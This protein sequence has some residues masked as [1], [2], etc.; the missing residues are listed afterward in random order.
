MFTRQIPLAV[1]LTVALTV[2]GCEVADEEAD[3]LQETWL[4]DA[5]Q[6]EQSAR[7]GGFGGIGGG[8]S[9]DRCTTFDGETSGCEDDEIC[10]PIAC[11]NAIPPFCFGFCQAGFRF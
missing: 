11:T 5:E 9:G 3:T 7:L 8:G 4:E 1:V 10:L 2:T 6:S